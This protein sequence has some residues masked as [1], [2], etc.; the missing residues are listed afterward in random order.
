MRKWLNFRYGK[1]SF[2]WFCS[3]KML[4]GMDRLL[5]AGFHYQLSNIPYFWKYVYTLGK[6]FHYNLWLVEQAKYIWFT[7]RNMIQRLSLTL[8]SVKYKN[9]SHLVAIIT[10]Y[11]VI[12]LLEP[13]FAISRCF[14]CFESKITNYLFLLIF[15]KKN[16]NQSAILR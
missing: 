1:R 3:Q 7:M 14:C 8:P 11:D 12:S 15:A 6:P 5:A 4:Y 9:M 16:L 10:K 13:V 2:I